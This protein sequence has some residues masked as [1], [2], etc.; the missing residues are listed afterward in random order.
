MSSGSGSWGDSVL[1]V[2]LREGP[3]PLGQAPGEVRLPVSP[4]HLPAALQ[5]T[6]PEEGKDKGEKRETFLPPASLEREP[7]G[8]S[9]FPVLH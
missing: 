4:P 6:R 3:C 2:W 9:V 8:S 7:E 5:L 1:W